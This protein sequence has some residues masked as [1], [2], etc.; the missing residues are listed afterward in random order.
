MCKHPIIIKNPSRRYR[1]GI[2]K[3]FFAVP[4]G[5]CSDCIKK[6]Q[7][8]WFVRCFFEFKR[9]KNIR[10]TI[11][12]PTFTYNDEN[13]PYYK[14]EENGFTCPCFSYSDIK[15]FRDKLRVLLSRSG[16]DSKGLRYII[17]SE[18]GGKYGRPHYHC[19]MFCPFKI[20]INDMLYFL[21]KSWTKGFVGVCKKGLEIKSVNGVQ[22]CM[23]YVSKEQHWSK[24]YGIYS[25]LNLLKNDVKL[26]KP[27]ASEKL[28]KFR[29]CMPKHYQSTNFGSYA[30]DKITDSSIIS[31]VIDLSHFGFITK[32][33]FKYKIPRYYLNKILKQNDLY[34]TQIPTERYEKLF[35]DIILKTFEND[36]NNLQHIKSY[37]DFCNHYKSLGMS[38]DTLDMY[39]NVIG[40]VKDKINY[41]VVF[42]HVYRDVPLLPNDSYEGLQFSNIYDL[43]KYYSIDKLME[44]AICFAYTQKFNYDTPKSEGCQ[45]SEILFK[46]FK[47]DRFT[48]NSLDCF[49][50]FSES[51][52]L[53]EELENK[54]SELKTSYNNTDY[55]KSVNQWR[56]KDFS[57][58]ESY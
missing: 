2:D 41:L 45:P 24:Y 6:D 39:Y 34:G 28:M 54:M 38:K 14:D 16:Y 27:S 53:I 46:L 18:Y 10:G 15:S 22:Y 52:T 51:L 26:Y 37:Y 5:Y 30:F 44:N 13:L 49:Q 57:L 35:V 36:Y 9:I 19:L 29:R 20:S 3:R 40:R 56:S 12:F 1:D 23:K 32:N 55:E 42:N 58:Y 50:N 48:F 31:G 11:F 7:D 43:N 21:R 4:C 25:Y 33:K 47:R 17:V 8:D